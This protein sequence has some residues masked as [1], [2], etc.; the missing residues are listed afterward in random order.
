[1]VIP[2]GNLWEETAAEA[3]DAP[4]LEGDLRVDI[5][6]VGAGYTGC[7][8]ALAAADKG[9]SVAVLEAETVGF[10]GSGRNVGLVNAGLWLPPDEVEGALGAGP[11]ARLIEALGQ[12]P[13]TV[14]DLI[15]RYQIRCEAR[16]NGTLHCAHKPSA[17]RDLERRASQWQARG[18]PVEVL[19]AAAAQAR[20]GS[21][22]V[23]GALLDHRAGTIQPLAYVRGLARAAVS[24]GAQ[25]FENT[26]V[27]GSR[28]EGGQWVLETPNG[29]V[30]AARVLVATNAYHLPIPGMARAQTS[31]VHF[32]Q[33]ATDPLENTDILQGE[34]GCWDT[35]LVMSSFRRDAAGR[36]IIGAMGLPERDGGLHLRWLQKKMTALF[37]DLGR[38]SLTGVW[39]GR[40]AMTRDHVP[41]LVRSGPGLYAIFGYSGRGI[42]PG[43]VMGLALG[44]GI[45]SGDLS[46]APL[47]AIETYGE[48]FPKLRSAYYEAG[49][50]LMHLLP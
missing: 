26:P 34:E 15:E 32:F 1:M 2:A 9:A 44:R 12:G 46:N 3:F 24:L 33:A 43:T 14:F 21:R 39:H 36:L 23:H 41:K 19:D 42:A 29:R 6:I 7:A 4:P 37:P 10:G 11:G 30:S 48:S 16:R 25:I 27:S 20:V 17:M 13:E 8:A 28:R 47:Q 45:L 31:L 18:A 5:A 22:A 49:A 40:I 38:Q 50:R 35:A